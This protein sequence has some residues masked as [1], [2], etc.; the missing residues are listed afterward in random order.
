MPSHGESPAAAA[1]Q[2]VDSGI[3]TTGGAGCPRIT[4]IRAFHRA[5]PGRA[6]SAAMCIDGG[7]LWVVLDPSKTAAAEHARHMLTAFGPHVTALAAE[8]IL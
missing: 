6:V 1:E 4:R 2:L 7:E 5:L 3:P 8:L